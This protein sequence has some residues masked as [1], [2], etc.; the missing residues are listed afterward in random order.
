MT[1]ILRVSIAALALVAVLVA[2]GCGSSD[3]S[4]TTA[5]TRAATATT[6]APAGGS[7]DGTAITTALKTLQSDMT[8]LGQSTSKCA[9]AGGASAVK[10]CVGKA[11]DKIAADFSSVSS[12]ITAQAQNASGACKTSLQ[13]FADAV[14]S[15]GGVMHKAASSLSSGD[16]AGASSA[17][18]QID[19]GTF[20]SAAT[21]ITTDCKPA[22]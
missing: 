13:T 21:A 3:K 17:L 19:N 12:T 14:K 10:S 16:I 20:T 22:G 18:S 8:S 9:Q 6:A 15:A 4:S 11:I 5:S 1:S 7:I 2:A